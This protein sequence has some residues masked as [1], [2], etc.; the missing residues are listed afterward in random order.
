[1][2]SENGEEKKNVE[3]VIETSPDETEAYITLIQLS[4]TPEFSVD[5]LKKA[6]CRLREEEVMS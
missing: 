5:D 1:M 3:I 2:N 6:L 4:E